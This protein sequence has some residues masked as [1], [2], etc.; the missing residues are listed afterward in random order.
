M[1]LRRP[2]NVP[3]LGEIM[4]VVFGSEVA[5][6]GGETYRPTIF[7]VTDLAQELYDI[8][9]GEGAFFTPEDVQN[10]SDVVVLGT[11]VKD[12][13]FGSANAVGERIKIKSKTYRVVGV[14]SSK[15]PGSLVNFDDIIMMPYTSAQQYVLGIKHYQRI[16][17]QA[18]TAEDVPRTVS[19][20]KATLR[21]SHRITDPKDDD[22]SIETQQDIVSRLGIITSVLTLLLSSIAAISLV[23]G[24]IGI[25]N[26]MLVSV[27]ERTREIGLRKAVGATTSHI[28]Q[29]FLVE[30]VVLTMLGG[31]I[32]ILFGMGFSFLVSLVMGQMGYNWSFIVPFYSVALAFV[33][34]TL[35]G[36]AFGIYPARRAARLHPIDALRYE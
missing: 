3:T 13:L 28:L 25:M 10:R 35:T 18:K 9:P 19:D 1:L 6:Y 27:T 4:P 31:I 20:I 22:F 29:Q 7:G 21:A 2:E 17:A 33:V 32:G 8:Y 30:A 5:S 12:E 11:K 14:L 16:A 26:I 23:V 15:G 24:G 36:L 34:S